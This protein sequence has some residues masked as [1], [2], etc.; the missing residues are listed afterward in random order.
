VALPRR[1]KQVVVS[2]L[3]IG[4]R[5]KLLRQERG[6]T[7]VEL[8][9]RLEITQSNLSAVERGVRGVTVNQIVRIAKALHASTDE[10]LLAEKAPAPGP[11]TKKRLMRRLLKIHELKDKD[12]R[13]LLEL[14]DSFVLASQKRRQERARSEKDSKVA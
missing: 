5:I 4:G 7:Q 12:Q 1:P 11:H 2:H 8:A 6:F 14:L 3:D 13:I 10:I 9:Q